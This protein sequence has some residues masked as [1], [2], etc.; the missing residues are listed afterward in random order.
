MKQRLIFVL[1][2][3]LALLLLAACSRDGTIGSAATA[4]QEATTTQVTMTMQGGT[5]A[6]EATIVKVNETDYKI[7]SSVT[8]FISGKPYH[9]EI[10]N[11]GNAVH[12]F[13][14]IPRATGKMHLRPWKS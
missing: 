2:S 5:V 6:Q 7:M 11:S 14:I 12:E 1:L 9:F 3:S 10:T 8:E 4:T 13:M